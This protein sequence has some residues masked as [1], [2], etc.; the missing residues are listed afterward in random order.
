MDLRYVYGAGFG[1][2]AFGSGLQVAEAALSSTDLLSMG[3][4][5]V[6]LVCFG[7][8]AWQSLAG[9]LDGVNEPA[10]S[11]FFTGL[12]YALLGMGVL[13]TALGGYG[14]ANTLL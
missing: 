11:G 4:D 8:L 12:G 3:L 2:M 1:L 14:L 7:I 13:L 5:G 10:S 6:L 9:K